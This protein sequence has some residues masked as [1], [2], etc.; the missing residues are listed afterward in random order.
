MNN[1]GHNEYYINIQLPI[2]KTVSVKRKK[3]TSQKNNR[4]FF[5]FLTINTQIKSC[6][7]KNRVPL[8][9]GSPLIKN[10]DF[11]KLVVVVFNFVC[12]LLNLKKRVSKKIELFSK[13]NIFKK[14][15]LIEIESY[16]F[17]FPE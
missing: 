12:K 11:S 5:F 16:I 8:H 7:M 14:F 2:D 3:K 13:N 10:F 1:K 17:P 9:T 4:K 15:I 6:F